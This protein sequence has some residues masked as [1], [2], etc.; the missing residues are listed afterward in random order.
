MNKVKFW[1]LIV[2]LSMAQVTQALC[3]DPAGPGV[4]WSK[5]GNFFTVGSCDKQDEILVGADL[6]DANLEGTNFSGA[7]LTGANLSGAN[8]KNADFSN[9]ILTGAKVNG[10]IFF[11]VNFENAL[12]NKIDFSVSKI[13]SWFD[14]NA[15][16]DS[17]NLSYSIFDGLILDSLDFSNS[18]IENT[19]FSKTS[20]Y[21]TKFQ[22]SSGNNAVFFRARGNPNFSAAILNN[23]DFRITDFEYAIFTNNVILESANFEASNLRGA[24]FIDANL[25]SASFRKAEAQEAEFIRINMTNADF[26]DA[27]LEYA[28]FKNISD[29]GVNYSSSTRANAVVRGIR[30]HPESPRGTC[31][32]APAEETLSDELIE[33][34]VQELI[35]QGPRVLEEGSRLLLD[36]LEENSN[37]SNELAPQL[38]TQ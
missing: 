9:A 35:N 21:N 2:C 37:D 12:A 16:F 28:K 7:N 10:A 1:L 11:N 6:T 4:D 34:A 27:T 22:S 31:E 29:D 5:D 38:P 19:S 30:C 17:A 20:L 8:L 15:S 26:E 3:S 23:A 25:V 18:Y 36:S 14:P 24:K 32:D 33:I 13:Y